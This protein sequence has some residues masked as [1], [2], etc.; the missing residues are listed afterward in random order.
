M[1]SCI[2]VGGDSTNVNTG[3]KGG[4][5]NFLEILLGRKV[6]WLVCMLH[7][8]EL[9]LRHLIINLDGKTSFDTGF[10]GPCKALSHVTRLLIKYPI[11]VINIGNNLIQLRDEIVHGLTDNQKY[12]YRMV[13]AIRTGE[14]PQDL[15]RLSISPVNHSRWLTTTNI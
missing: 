4:A 3:W 12:G 13:K 8:N 14:L 15:A 7:T 5:I 9:P 11:D 6:I 10:T 2:T 1:E